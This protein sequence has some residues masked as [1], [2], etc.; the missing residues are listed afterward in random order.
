MPWHA[1]ALLLVSLVWGSTF[2]VLKFST[3][4]L[5]GVELSALRFALAALCLLPWAWRASRA[6]WRG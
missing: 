4:A 1:L 6:A 2:A 3:Q 5:S